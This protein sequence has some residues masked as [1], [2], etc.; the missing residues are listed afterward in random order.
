M[1]HSLD[2]LLVRVAEK[3]FEKLAFMF[4]V[5]EDEA[6]DSAPG[7][8]AAGVSFEGA[9]QG[10]LIISITDEMLPALAM[11]M[12]GLE[13][14]AS[15][16]LTQQHDALKE[17]A[18]VVCGNLLPE[19]AG[20]QVEFRVGAPELNEKDFPVEPASGQ[21]QAAEVCLILDSGQVKLALFL[22]ND[23]LAKDAVL[24]AERSQEAR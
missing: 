8:T 16:T 12:L 9:F 13:E 14:Q 6:A 3:T 10:Q 2:D 21:K 7:A 1:T 20:P 15:P 19:I 11:N 18:N 5:S 4:A 23:A 22:D 24:L 17:L